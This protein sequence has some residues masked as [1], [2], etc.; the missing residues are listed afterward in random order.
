MALKLHTYVLKAVPLLVS[1]SGDNPNESVQRTTSH[2]VRKVS[3]DDTFAKARFS[4]SE[5]ITWLEPRMGHLPPTDKE[6]E[7]DLAIGGLRNAP[8]A[9][10]RLHKVATFG[11]KLGAALMDLIMGNETQHKA[12]GTFARVLDSTDL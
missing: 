5:K 8:A 1:A 12:A 2:K 4:F 9:V 6:I 10:A 7:D 11:R 3:K